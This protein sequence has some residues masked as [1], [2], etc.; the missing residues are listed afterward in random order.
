MDSKNTK[1]DQ[2]D[3]SEQTSCERHC[4]VMGCPASTEMAATGAFIGG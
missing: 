2:L 3:Y 1:N 4:D